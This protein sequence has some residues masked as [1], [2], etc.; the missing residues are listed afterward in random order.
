MTPKKKILVID[1]EE[2][3]RE[4][5]A[6]LLQLTGYEVNVAMNGKDGLEKVK[7]YLPDLIICDVVMP[8]RDGYSVLLIL[9]QSLE[10][11]SIP[12]IF[13]TSK[14]ERTEQRKGMELGADDYLLKPFE[15]VE[16]LRAIESRLNKRELILAKATTNGTVPSLVPSHLSEDEERKQLIKAGKCKIYDPKEFVFRPGDH[17]NLVYY[18]KGGAVKTY[19]LNAEGKQFITGIH[20]AGEYIGYLALLESRSYEQYAEVIKPSEI[21][22]IPKQNFLES[23]AKNADFAAGFMTRLSKE[24]SK[25]NGALAQ[26]AYDTVRKR[27]GQKLLEMTD[28]SEKNSIEVSRVDLAALVG[29][30]QE[31]LV[32]IL[33]EFRKEKIIGIKGKEIILLEQKKLERI[34]QLC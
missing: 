34:I 13:L 22:Q 24:L 7:T 27:V 28:E 4:N 30:A 10:T 20:E 16:L 26:L 1:D 12:F 2:A 32:R 21:F 25:K 3:I 9:S 14:A 29:T 8:Y 19:L 31:T 18:I 15:D 33:S 17:P 11:A 23:I 6:E 5:I